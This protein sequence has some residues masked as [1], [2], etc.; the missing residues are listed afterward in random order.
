M[1]GEDDGDPLVIDLVQKM[2]HVVARADVES[3]RRFVEQNKFWIA[4]QGA[5]DEHRLLL[6]AGEFA[7][8]AIAQT[9][10][11]QTFHD[12]VQFASFLSPMPPSQRF[13]TKNPMAMT[14]S[15]VIG[16]FQSMVSSC[17]T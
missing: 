8:V 12:F 14:S 9:V 5:A 6:A 7:N 16:K 1:R 11:I 4:E 15:T 17:G 10:E 2:N 13:L 3:R